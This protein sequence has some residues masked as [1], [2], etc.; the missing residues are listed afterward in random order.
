MAEY[1]E[2]GKAKNESINN[3]KYTWGG[4]WKMA[5][6]CILIRRLILLLRESPP[7][8]KDAEPNYDPT[9]VPSLQNYL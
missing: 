6:P 1:F 5:D 8:P 7:S 2:G 3:M 9:S 4:G